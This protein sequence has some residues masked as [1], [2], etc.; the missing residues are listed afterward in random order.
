MKSTSDSSYYLHMFYSCGS[1]WLILNRPGPSC[2][3]E[4]KTGKHPGVLKSGAG[5]WFTVAL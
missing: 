2:R 5:L 4:Q 3:M 1:F